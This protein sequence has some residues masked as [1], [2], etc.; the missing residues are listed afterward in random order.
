VNENVFQKMSAKQTI[1]HFDSQLLMRGRA[2]K[3]SCQEELIDLT[4]ALLHMVQ[5]RESDLAHSGLKCHW[6]SS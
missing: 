4:V 1:S 6:R 3:S 5:A 2:L